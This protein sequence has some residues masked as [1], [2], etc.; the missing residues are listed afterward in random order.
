MGF[1][2]FC[3]GKRSS[4]IASIRDVF[5]ETSID[6]I[7]DAHSTMKINLLRTLIVMNFQ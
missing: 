6:L 3:D 4:Q 2:L 1:K 5:E 7:N